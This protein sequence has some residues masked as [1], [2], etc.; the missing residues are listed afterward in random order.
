MLCLIIK[1]IGGLTMR[2]NDRFDVEDYNL[3]FDSIYNE[4][5]DDIRLT[6]SIWYT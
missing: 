1:L 3:E 5:I 6:N 2:Q 4:D